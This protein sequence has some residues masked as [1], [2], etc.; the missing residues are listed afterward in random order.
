MMNCDNITLVQRYFYKKPAILA[1]FVQNKL[2]WG[3]WDLHPTSSG[4]VSRD[5]PFSILWK[6]QDVFF[7]TW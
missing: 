4:D 2:W 7:C 1:L 5:S 6:N 3:R